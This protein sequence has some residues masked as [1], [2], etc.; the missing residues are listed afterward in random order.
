[1]QI[2]KIN[3]F[4]NRLRRQVLSH[5]ILARIIL[6]IFILVAVF[7]GWLLFHSRIQGLFS[8]LRAVAGTPLP[9]TDGRTNL[10]F[11][12]S[13][14]DGHQGPDLTDTIIFVSI[15]DDT[16]ETT[17]ISVPRD[18]WIPSL[19]AKINSAFHY[20]YVKQATDG[21]LL[22]AKSAVSEALN[23]PVHFAVK[24]DFSTFARAIDLLGGVDITVDRTFDDNRYPITGKE[25]DLCDGD[26]EYLCRYEHV[27]FD[28]GPQ[29]MDGA[30]A[31][32]FVRSRYS[33]DPLEGTDFARN[34]RQEKVISAVKSRLVS[35]DNLT[36][37]KLYTQLYDLAV[38]SVVTDITPDYYSS[39][40]RLGLKMRKVPFRSFSL[41][42]PD[43][44]ENPPVS[45]K[46]DFQWVLIHKDGDPEI[47][48]DYVSSLLSGN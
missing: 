41:S 31:L 10:V 43:Q 26:P 9:Q 35:I 27:H 22:L 20:G 3:H 14:G 37:T 28:A 29:H 39:F 45:P 21:G 23:Q 38:R 13:G 33:D 24:I 18:L 46:Y 8:D 11:L 25:N 6:V 16:G 40:L 15:K 1:M 7:F 19:R 32:K 48:F 4:Y 30:T 17:L 2:S 36:D 47:I 12:G 5:V 42:V 44:L 34:Q